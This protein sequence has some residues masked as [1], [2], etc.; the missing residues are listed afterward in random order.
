MDDLTIQE[1]VPMERSEPPSLLEETPSLQLFSKTER[2][3]IELTL[4]NLTVD[5][6]ALRLALPKG[7]VIALLS[8]PDIQEHLRVLSEAMNQMETLRLKGLCERMLDEKLSEAE[9]NGTSITKKDALE[10]VKVYHDIVS[11]ERKSKQPKEEQN[12]YLNI[13]TQV[14]Q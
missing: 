14:M 5:V 7:T 13:L 12:I 1:L 3:L 4:E 11:A 6:I 2:L 8:K 10:I 9:E